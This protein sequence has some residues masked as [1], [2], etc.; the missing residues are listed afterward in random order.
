MMLYQQTVNSIGVHCASQAKK[1]QKI[2]EITKKEKKQK[3]GLRDGS[4]FNFYFSS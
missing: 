3:K 2:T 4:I 1:V